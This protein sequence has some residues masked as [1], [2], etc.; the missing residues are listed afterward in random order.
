MQNEKPKRKGVDLK[1][2]LANKAKTIAP[3]KES[4][5]N[6][7]TPIV[8]VQK[9]TKE[10]KKNNAVGS[11]KETPTSK[12]EGNKLANQT[13][14]KEPVEIRELRKPTTYL[15]FIDWLAQPE[16]LRQPASQ[17]AFADKYK[18][19]EDTLTRWKQRPNF[20]TLHENRVRA[21]WREKTGLA[22][23]A[24]FA[25]LLRKGSAKEFMAFVQYIN[26]FNPKIV[27]ENPDDFKEY[28]P[29]QLEEMAKAM[30]NAGL[31]GVTAEH[32][33]MAEVFNDLAI[34][35]EDDDDSDQVQES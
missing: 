24:L 9:G 11:L 10:A 2:F 19:D 15:L 16:G 22:V 17:K 27:V 6:P 28:D 3:T 20:W 5:L 12:R 29:A 30:R 8:K 7:E 33:K 25:N 18:V 31:A 13:D 4:L 34:E 26:L 21:Q 23:N 32:Q 35:D 1:K 14:N